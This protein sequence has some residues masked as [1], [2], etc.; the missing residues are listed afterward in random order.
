MDAENDGSGSFVEGQRAS[1][2]VPCFPFSFFKIRIYGKAR[3][4]THGS[5][6]HGILHLPFRFQK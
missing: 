1:F 3:H 4:G 6:W 5:A 2:S